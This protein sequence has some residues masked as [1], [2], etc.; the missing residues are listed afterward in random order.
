MI[1][2]SSYF[3]LFA[4]HLIS[5]QPAIWIE[6]HRPLR[7]RLR[8]LSSTNRCDLCVYKG[9]DTLAAFAPT[10]SWRLTARNTC[11]LVTRM[12]CTSAAPTKGPILVLFSTVL[13]MAWHFTARSTSVLPIHTY[14]KPIIVTMNLE[15]DWEQINGDGCV[16][17]PTNAFVLR[18]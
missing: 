3:V 18:H 14:K 7:V 8:E 1:V 5:R 15:Q 6:A 17:I 16:W 4:T 10:M 12:W 11:V 2:Q 13:S 9:C